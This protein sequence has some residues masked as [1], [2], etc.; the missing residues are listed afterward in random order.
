VDDATIGAFLAGRADG[1]RRVTLRHL[2]GSDEG[3]FLDLV[4]ASAELHHPWMS[5]PSTPELYRA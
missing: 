3:E 5:L 2:G 4:Q 1:A